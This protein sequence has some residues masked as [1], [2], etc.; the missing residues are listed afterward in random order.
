MQ[1]AHIDFERLSISPLNMR[2][3]RKAPDVSDILPSIRARGVL[4]PLLVRPNGTP[5]TYEVVAGRRRYFCAKA[6]KEEGGDLPPLPCGI[7]EEGDDAA[8][9]EASLIENIARR[10][11]DEMSQYETFAQLVKKGRTVSDIVATFGITERQVT[12]RLAL[13]NLLP[14][15]REAYR[16]EQIDAE[17]V[18]HLTL[19]TKSQQKEWLALFEDEDSHAPMGSDL[20]H[21][22]F[23]GQSVSTK[24]SLFPLEDYPGEIVSDLFG[25]DRYFADA[26]LFWR[27]QNEAVAARKA[28][29]A[30]AGWSDVIVLET[31]EHFHTWEYEK[32]AK[33][34]GGKVYIEVTQRG[35]VVIH[36]GYLS[37]KEAA[38]AK[39]AHEPKKDGQRATAD[40]PEVSSVM[41]NYLDLHR[42]A[43]VRA[44]LL[45]EPAV[46]LRL[47]LAHAISGSGRWQV[48]ADPQT[49]KNEAIAKSVEQSAAERAFRAR[50]AEIATLLGFSDDRERIAEGNGDSYQT[51]AIFARLL[52][53]SDED[54]SRILAL[55]MAETLEAGSAVVEAVGA[56]LRLDLRGQWQAD[57]TFLELV[58]DRPAINA[59]LESV[60]GKAVADGNVTSKAK[61]QRQIIRDCLGGANGRTKVENWLPGWM[62]FPARAVTA[63]GSLESVSE[64]ERVREL[65]PQG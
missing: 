45:D 51:V 54:V 18:R 26:T 24:V 59:L 9:L 28:A 34:K 42:H 47:M 13:G 41:Q 30:E 64:W 16:A 48:R 39:R 43:A 8:A 15:I 44:R 53:L 6:V 29:F 50:R 22:L 3:G 10:D 31:G 56:H 20:K 60:A 4:V 25:E 1:L 52:A 17:T 37:R 7:M 32:T 55:V 61:D 5:D 33:K 21:W 14:R 57:D 62:E 23:G 65:L 19:A 11:P 49:A 36:E 12:Q 2:H 46:V 40:H 38:R 27:K 35:E 58:R 63:H